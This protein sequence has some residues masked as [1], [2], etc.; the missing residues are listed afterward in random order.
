VPQRRRRGRP[1]PAQKK[2]QPRPSPKRSE[3]KQEEPS[4]P[5]NASGN[6]DDI[7]DFLEEIDAPV[8]PPR[9]LWVQMNFAAYGTPEETESIFDALVGEAR[10]R[11]L[12]Y[13]GQG[14][15]IDLD[16]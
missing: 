15:V 11:G 7:P 13:L 1:S 5:P 14:F 8:T 10:V 16:D 4:V 6:P 3:A 2:V 9:R 12:D